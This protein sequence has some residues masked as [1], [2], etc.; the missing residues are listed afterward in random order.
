MLVFG[1]SFPIILQASED[2]VFVGIDVG[3]G[4]HLIRSG[5]LESG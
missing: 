5:I 3:L 4:I 1:S 2:G